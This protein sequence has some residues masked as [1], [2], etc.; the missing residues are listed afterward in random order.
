MLKKASGWDSST[1]S[2]SCMSSTLT[3]RIGPSGGV[4]SPK[5]LTSAL[6]NGRSHAK[7]LPRTNQVR[8]PWRNPS[9][10]SGRARAI[11]AASSNVAGTGRDGSRLPFVSAEDAGGP[12]VGR[13]VDRQRLQR[14]RLEA[15]RSQGEDGLLA[16]NAATELPATAVHVLYRSDDDPATAT[17]TGYLAAST[18][19]RWSAGIGSHLTTWPTGQGVDAGT[20]MADG[21]EATDGAVGYSDT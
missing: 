6:L 16:D 12:R 4:S 1:A 15:P 7:P 11:A 3:A 19:T 13:G 14:W 8:R 5:R 2:F 17:L 20:A 10:T 18:P 9:V 21:L